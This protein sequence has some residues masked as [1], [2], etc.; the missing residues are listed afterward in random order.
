MGKKLK[1]DIALWEGYA[2]Q[3]A[4]DPDAAIRYLAKARNLAPSQYLADVADADIAYMKARKGDVKGA[5]K[6]IQALLPRYPA[7]TPLGATVRQRAG[8]Y[9]DRLGRTEEAIKMYDTVRKQCRIGEPQ[10]KAAYLGALRGLL[11]CYE[12]QG[13]VQRAL[14]V[15]ATLRKQGQLNWSDDEIRAKTI[16]LSKAALRGPTAAPVVQS[17]QP[18]KTQQVP[19]GGRDW[20]LVLRMIQSMPGAKLSLPS[21]PTPLTPDLLNK[22]FHRI[23]LLPGDLSDAQFLREL[24]KSFPGRK[25]SILWSIRFPLFLDHPLR[26][27]QTNEFAHWEGIFTLSFAEG[28]TSLRCRTRAVNATGGRDASDTTFTLYTSRVDNSVLWGVPP[29][30]PGTDGNAPQVFV[31]ATTVPPKSRQTGPKEPNQEKK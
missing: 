30:M 25:Y 5:L 2:S 18:A 26:V 10:A 23:G 17:A 3:R 28:K 14:T 1:A 22:A 9:L 6:G 12:K 27:A 15:A 11:E 13:D 16:A 24:S 4:S 29:G 31:L 21:V 7:D 20:L 8:R 19:E